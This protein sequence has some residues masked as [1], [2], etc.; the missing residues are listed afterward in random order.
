MTDDNSRIAPD[1]LRLFRLAQLSARPLAAGEGRHHVPPHRASG[2]R[3]LRSGIILINF[4]QK[5]GKVGGLEGR[6]SPILPDYS[7]NGLMLKTL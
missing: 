4:K 1:I 7:W 5:S 2:E 6:Y 3:Q